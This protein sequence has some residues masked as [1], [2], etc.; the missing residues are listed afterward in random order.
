[1][2]L[3]GGHDHQVTSRMRS[4]LRTSQNA[5]DLSLTLCLRVL[6]RGDSVAVSDGLVGAGSKQNPD[7]FLVPRAAVSVDNGFQ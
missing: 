6:Q 2:C 5:H 1:M 7:D 3:L 4:R